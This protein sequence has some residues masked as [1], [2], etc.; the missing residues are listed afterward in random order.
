MTQVSELRIERDKDVTSPSVGED[1]ERD[2][3]QGKME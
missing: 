2:A 3:P 1:A